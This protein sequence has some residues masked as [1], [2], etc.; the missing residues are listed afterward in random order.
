[1]ERNG[2]S[3]IKTVQMDN[4]RGLPGIR[5]IDRE[6]NTR[7]REECGVAKLTDESVLH[8]F[9]HFERMVNDRIAKSVYVGRVCK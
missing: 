8:L 5:R 7:I 3:R 2:G 9:G 4:L 1:M 6:P